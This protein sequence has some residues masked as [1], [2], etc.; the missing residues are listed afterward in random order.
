MWILIILLYIPRCFVSYFVCNYLFVNIYVNL[1]LDLVAIV[2][3]NL[4]SYV[5]LFY[6][7]T[8]SLVKMNIGTFLIHHL[9]KLIVCGIYF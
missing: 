7:D 1:F 6:L 3:I 2:S 8:Y 4:F 9:I 5:N